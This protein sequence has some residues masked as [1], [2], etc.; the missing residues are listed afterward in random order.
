MKVRLRK[1]DI[2]FSRLVRERSNYYC[3]NCCTNKREGFLDCAHI[4]GRRSVALRWHPRNATSLCRPCHMF[5]TE[6]P[7][8]FSDWCKDQFGED[9]IAE[10]RLV[11]TKPVKWNKPL[12]EEIYQHYRKELL[13]MQLK[14]LD[15]QEVIE[16]EQHECMHIFDLVE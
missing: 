13:S 1:L 11:S 5:F 12:R 9:F 7:F 3:E 14:R 2:V 8:D 16:F 10:L 15:T 6:H 4:M